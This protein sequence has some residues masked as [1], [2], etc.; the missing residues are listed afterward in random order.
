[1]QRRLLL[2]EHEAATERGNARQH[3]VRAGQPLSPKCS[4]PNDTSFAAHAANFYV[5]TTL[6]QCSASADVDDLA[7]AAI[8]VM[9]YVAVPMLLLVMHCLAA[10][11]LR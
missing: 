10:A 1:M 6:H 5:E 8:R 3:A 2:A 4:A 9:A 11:R 7:G